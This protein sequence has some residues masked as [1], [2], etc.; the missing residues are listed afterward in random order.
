MKLS[1]ALF[2]ASAAFCIQTALA[3]SLLPPSTAGSDLPNLMNTATNDS[4]VKANFGRK[5]EKHPAFKKVMDQVEKANKEYFKSG[6]FNANHPSC[7]DFLFVK[8]KTEKAADESE[9]EVSDEEFKFDHKS[10]SHILA[11]LIESEEMYL[12]S[13]LADKWIK[14]REW[15]QHN[16]KVIRKDLLNIISALKKEPQLLILTVKLLVEKSAME[17][18]H[19]DSWT[20]VVISLVKAESKIKDL[21]EEDR[22]ETVAFMIAHFFR[23]ADEHKRK[24]GEKVVSTMKSE[25]EKADEIAKSYVARF[26]KQFSSSASDLRFTSVVGNLPTEF[27]SMEFEE[28]EYDSEVEVID[29]KIPKKS[30]RDSKSKSKPTSKPIPSTGSSKGKSSRN[31]LLKAMSSSSTLDKSWYQSSMIWISVLAIAGVLCALLGFYACSSKKRG[32]EL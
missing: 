31:S 15:T 10:A 28:D 3:S 5:R 8:I 23:V 20:S 6:N 9:D 18:I 4:S 24:F 1:S 27:E 12:A 13:A 25:L 7:Y 19:E 11:Y 29:L 16:R 17:I 21:S 32:V 22:D 2:I 26:A 30:Q 14:A